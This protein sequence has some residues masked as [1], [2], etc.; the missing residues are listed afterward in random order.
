[1]DFETPQRFSFSDDKLLDSSEIKWE[2]K[3]SDK[4]KRDSYFYQGYDDM[5]YGDFQ[6]WK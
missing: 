2:D 4:T 3:T 5:Q 6:K 1:M